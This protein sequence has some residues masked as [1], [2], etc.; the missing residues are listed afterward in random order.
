MWKVIVYEMELLSESQKQ[1]TE[2]VCKNLD[3]TQ[4]GVKLLKGQGYVAE[5]S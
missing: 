1:W 2:N 5:Y 3:F 4:I